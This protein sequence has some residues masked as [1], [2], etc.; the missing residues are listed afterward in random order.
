MPDAVVLTVDAYTHFLSENLLKER[1]TLELSRKPLEDMRWEEVWDTALRIR[2]LFLSHPIPD[3]T[4]EMLRRQCEGRFRNRPLAVRSSAPGEDDAQTSFAGLH[5]SFVNV[6]G[7][8]AVIDRVRQVWASLWSDAAL[9]YRREMGLDVESSAMAVIIQLMVDGNRSGVVFSRNP[10][11]DDQA[12]VEAVY[13]LNQGLVD[14][15]VAPDRWIFDREGRRVSHSPPR[16]GS[17]PLSPMGVGFGSN[18]SLPIWRTSR[19]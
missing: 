13:G 2:H 6:R 18:P 12:V 14:G 16:T 5:E 1:V 15:T 3:P 10:V 4:V 17:R 7:V 11:D 8:D 19:R 9:L